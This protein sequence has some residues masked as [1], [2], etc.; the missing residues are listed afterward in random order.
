MRSVTPAPAALAPEQRAV[1]QVWNIRAHV[2]ILRRP[3][4]MGITAT[5][6]SVS[7]PQLDG[8]ER[9]A[10]SLDG[11]GAEGE[12][13]D[14]RRSGAVPHAGGAVPH[15][16]GAV[17]HADAAVHAVDTYSRGAL[18]WGY[19]LLLNAI[20]GAVA[21]AFFVAV[22]Y[23]DGLDPYLMGTYQWLLGHPGV[24]STLAFSPLACSLL[25]GYGYA[26]RARKRKRLAA[27]RALKTQE[28]QSAKSA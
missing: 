17:P 18:R 24:T 2:A 11:R 6:P 27:Q 21:V 5:N 23:A 25:V 20:A 3:M 10:A 14:S 8:V 9:R 28:L 4:A 22:F 13:G 15:A 12:S 19:F 26:S 16:D 7:K 1:K